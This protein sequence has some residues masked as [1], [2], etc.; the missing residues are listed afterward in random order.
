MNAGFHQVVIK[1]SGLVLLPFLFATISS[2][3]TTSNPPVPNAVVRAGRLL[4]SGSADSHVQSTRNDLIEVIARPVPDEKLSVL[5]T[6][7]SEADA[8]LESRLNELQSPEPAREKSLLWLSRVELAV[9]KSE[10][11]AEGSGDGIASA[12]EAVRIAEAAL[13]ALPADGVARTEVLRLLAEAH[14]RQ[15]DA[16]SAAAVLRESA[17]ATQTTTDS[18]SPSESVEALRVRIAISAGDMETARKML[19]VVY[20]NDPDAATVGI[21]MDLVRLRYLLAKNQERSVA[22]WMERILDRHG[23]NA[24]DRADTIVAQTR[25]RSG[26]NTATSP[27]DG[28]DPRL[29]IADAMYYLRRGQFMQAALH[30]AKAAVSD[31]VAS[32]SVDSAM[33][34]AA[35]LS[36][37]SNPKAAIELLRRI[38]QR[39]PTSSKSADALL[40]AATI[41]QAAGTT[42]ASDSKIEAMLIEIANQWPESPSAFAAMR[43]RVAWAERKSDWLEAAKIAVQFANVH[44]ADESSAALVRTQAIQTWATAWMHGPH[45][46]V[47]SALHAAFRERDAM[48]SIRQTHADLAILLAETSDPIYR[49][50]Q[51]ETSDGFFRQLALFRQ[52]QTDAIQALPADGLRQVLA[53]RLE[54]D[55][56]RNPI[57]RVEVGRYLLSLPPVED[58]PTDIQRAGWLIWSG[59]RD[60]AENLIAQELKRTPSDAEQWCRRAATSYAVSQS[61]SDQKQAA[62]WWKRL[63]DGRPQGDPAWHSAM[64]GWIQSIAASGQPDKAK[65]SAKMILL[66]I[67]PTDRETQN[68][69]QNTSN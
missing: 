2:A 59:Q 64:I 6:N 56:V 16:R 9:L 46:E 13:L 49:E 68:A 35:I 65:A 5:L 21:G 44:W 42:V 48:Q 34:S 14:L 12:A 25:S 61:K 28:S 10:L 22:D 36:R 54:W 57:R 24:K 66:T 33:K 43:W 11:F 69:Y 50:L 39:H 53:E 37:Q 38:S 45:S 62:R 3:Q 55:V 7:V 51:K 1:G 41:G 29:W 27:A 17:L 60:A 19:D 30:F 47:I 15:G 4:D 40:Q 52:S 67:P 63:A 23:V 18:K 31:G 20:G 32:R 58:F 8:K 26:M